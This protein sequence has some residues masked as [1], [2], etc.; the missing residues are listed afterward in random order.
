MIQI[1]LLPWRKQARQIQK[2]QFMI[3]AIISVCVALLAI[4]ILHIYFRMQLGEQL[5]LN[6]YLKS[7]IAIEQSVTETFTDTQKKKVA[8]EKQLHFISSLFATSYNA[9]RVLNELP[10]IVPSN[11]NLQKVVRN[12]NLIDLSGIT[13]SDSEVT[14]FKQILE[15]SAVFGSPVV[16]QISSEKNIQKVHFEISITLKDVKK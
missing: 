3:G 4:I 14:L 12:D 13:Q 10:A 8:L 5:A 1:N 15:K 9:I 2:V 7:E 11:I 6:D 16:K